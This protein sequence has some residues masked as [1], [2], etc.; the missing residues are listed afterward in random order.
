MGFIAMHIAGFTHAKEQQ[1]A[2]MMPSG[3]QPESDICA[4]T[5]YARNAS[6]TGNSSPLRL[7]T[8]FSRTVETRHCFGMKAT[9][10]PCVSLVTIIKLAA[11]CKGLE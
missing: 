7:S 5:H 11:A 2:A 4:G 8:I 1:H 9:G 3:A 6:A 10:K